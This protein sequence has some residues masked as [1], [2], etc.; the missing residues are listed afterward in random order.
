MTRGPG[1]GDGRPYSGQG[2]S[3]FT[4][5]MSF[6][7]SNLFDL[8]LGSPSTPPPGDGPGSLCLVEAWNAGNKALV[9]VVSVCVLG[10][11]V[12]WRAVGSPGHCALSERR[13]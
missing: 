5:K 13:R 7:N 9:H 8:N 1:A 6:G 12:H 10:R 3:S 4:G 11:P 2:P